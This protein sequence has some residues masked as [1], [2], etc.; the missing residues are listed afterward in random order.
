M[1]GY[2]LWVLL[3]GII[4]VIAFVSDSR[5]K[6][7]II[8]SSLIAMPFGFGELYFIPNYWTPATLFNLGTK[9]SIDLESFALMFFLGGIAA[10]VYEGIFKKRIPAKQK[11]CGSVCKCYTP[12]ITTLVVFII[13]SKLFPG[14]NIIY[15]SSIAGI[16][17]G[18]MAFIVYPNLR[19]HVLFGGFLFAILYWLS[20]SLVEVFVPGWISSTWN[21]AQMSQIIILKVPIEEILFGLSFGFIWT[22]LFEEVCSNFHK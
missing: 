20:L 18:L 3:L 5:L 17:G 16:S 10:F 2:L 15:P 11:F 12:L 1:E 13:F 14:L 21:M 6:K 19:K 22:P 7:K 9:Y 8:W 4:W